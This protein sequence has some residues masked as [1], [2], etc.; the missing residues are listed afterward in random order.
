M[1]FLTSVKT[2]SVY[3]IKLGEGYV[4]CIFLAF[5]VLIDQVLFCEL[6]FFLVGIMVRSQVTVFQNYSKITYVV[7]KIICLNSEYHQHK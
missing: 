5:I 4:V 1:H 2:S 3:Y 7:H 6:N